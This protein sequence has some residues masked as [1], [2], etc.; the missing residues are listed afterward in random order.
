MESD[1]CAGEW[2]SKLAL[3]RLQKDEFRA[4]LSQRKQHTQEQPVEQPMEQP[5]CHTQEEETQQ[6]QEQPPCQMEQQQTHQA[7]LAAAPVHA[8]GSGSVVKAQPSVKA[9]AAAELLRLRAE[10]LKVEETVHRCKA[11]RR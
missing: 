9:R 2:A 11:S 1:Q 4:R 5:Q 7:A 8:P 6:T 10:R 3:M